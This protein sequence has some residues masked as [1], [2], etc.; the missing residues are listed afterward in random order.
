VTSPDV[1][2]RPH[3]SRDFFAP[4]PQ[5]SGPAVPSRQTPGVFSIETHPSPVRA[6]E[7]LIASPEVATLLGLPDPTHHGPEYA[8]LFSGNQLP[9]GTS[10]YA[11]RYGGHQFGHWAG[12]L[13]DGRA[14]S[15]GELR[16][17][18]GILR[19]V[20][21]KGAGPTPY[22]RRAD[23]RAV[24]RSSLREFLCSE[25]MHSLGIPTTR[26]L[27]CVTTGE[28]VIRDMFYDGNPEAEPGA[29]TTRVAESFIRFGHFEMP[30]HA[31]ELENL[32]ALLNRTQK[33]F[34]PHHRV[35]TPEGIALWLAEV[36]TRTARLISE[37]LRV[38]FVH[39]VMNTDNLSILGLTI[40]YGPYGWLEIHDPQWTPNTTDAE[41][42]RYAYGRQPGVGQW[43]LARLAEALLPL[44]D[45]QEQGVQLLTP[46]LETYNSTFQDAFFDM[47]CRKL[48]LGVLERSTLVPLLEKLEGN[49]QRSE[50]DP[51]LFYRS[52]AEI[53]PDE[54]TAE[55][56]FEKILP[57]QYQTPS[58]DVRA[59]WEA[60]LGDY[61]NI[62]RQHGLA[63]ESRVATM[64]AANPAFVLRNSLVQ[65]AL[66]AIER[67]DRS[68]MH[69]LFEA[70]KTPY[71]LNDKTTSY[72]KRMP[73]WARSRPG[74]SALS[75]SS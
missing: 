36:A 32:R 29:I 30:A 42:R 20:Q 41:G 48:G 21:L 18:D 64:N 3:F 26:A 74:C 22:S 53:T 61:I 51:T 23:G 47:T 7:L 62:T 38:G 12:Q 11:T 71:E 70:L 8:A 37:W 65:E 66:D 13:G 4:L 60:W 72:F 50:T 55:Q 43:N 54:H 16:G 1:P 24:L 40:D 10:P 49:L 56:A 59:D 17:P 2:L 58:P 5:G 67:G 35:D 33:R 34:F 15:L 44:F 9:E 75:C 45:S 39:G 52:L 19:E 63:P 69:K 31:G 73:D 57:S 27:C 68:P 28:S 6:P 14:I 25:A 46:V